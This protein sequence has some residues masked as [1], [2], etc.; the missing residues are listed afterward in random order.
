MRPPPHRGNVREVFK[1]TGVRPAAK[2]SIDG[3]PIPV[4]FGECT[5]S[6]ALFCHPSDCGEKSSTGFGVSDIDA[7][8]CFEKREDAIPG[9]HH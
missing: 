9:P 2:P 7:W 8:K 3:V 4:N 1:D 6:R 5:P